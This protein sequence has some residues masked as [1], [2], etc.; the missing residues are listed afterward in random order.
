MIL[1]RRILNK[2]LLLAGRQFFAHA[3]R[4]VI[5]PRPLLCNR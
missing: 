2:F 4:S 3:D 5:R 1:L